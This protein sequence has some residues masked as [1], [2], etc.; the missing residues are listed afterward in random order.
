VIEAVVKA[1]SGDCGYAVVA[2]YD[3]GA[4][5]AWTGFADR[6]AAVLYKCAQVQEDANVVACEVLTDAEVRARAA[7]RHTLAQCAFMELARRSRPWL[8]VE[9]D[10]DRARVVASAS[11]LPASADALHDQLRTAKELFVREISPST[12]DPVATL[13]KSCAALDTLHWFEG[14]ASES[15]DAADQAL[16]ALDG[17]GRPGP[18]AATVRR[19]VN[20]CPARLTRV[21]VG[22]YDVTQ[23]YAPQ[24]SPT[25]STSSASTVTSLHHGPGHFRSVSEPFPPG[26]LD[27][28][29]T[30]PTPA[31]ALHP[32][33]QLEDLHN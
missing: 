8:S 18:D 31:A 24:P 15:E 7:K 10:G 2:A 11:A 33:T 23:W 29:P 6:S 12:T 16:Q 28:P 1:A 13:L 20:A 14:A 30:P 26:W 22:G 25:S 27:E 3:S 4:L 17:N 32:L 21:V 19:A 5:E 9:I